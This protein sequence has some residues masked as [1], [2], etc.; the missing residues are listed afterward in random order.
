MRKLL[1]K[2]FHPFVRMD[3][4]ITTMQPIKIV[5]RDLIIYACYFENKRKGIKLKTTLEIKVEKTNVNRLP[6]AIASM[7]VVART[8]GKYLIF[9]TSYKDEILQFEEL[10]QKLNKKAILILQ[11]PSVTSTDV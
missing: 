10:V 5:N 11:K 2:I 6:I 9:R 7:F 3:E 8:S 4:V 1:Y